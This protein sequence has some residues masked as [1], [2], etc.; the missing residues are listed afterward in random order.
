MRTIARYECASSCA[1]IFLGGSERVLWGSRAAIGLH[2]AS[3]VRGEGNGRTITC[4]TARDDPSPQAL[5]RHLRFVVPETAEEII[6]IVMATPCTQIEWVKGSR[7]LDLQ[8]AT[9]IEAP[10]DDVFGP[11]DERT[12]ASPEVPR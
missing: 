9:R 4:V 3:S 7:A 11:R 2:Q 12:G 10:D 6:R 1:N 8:V 5:R